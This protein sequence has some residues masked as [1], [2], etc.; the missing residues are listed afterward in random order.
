[1]ISTVQANLDRPVELLIERSGEEVTIIGTPSS[2]RTKQE[3]SLG[4]GL[5]HP[6]RP[7]TLSEIASGG[8]VITA[9]QAAMLVYIP[10][11]LIQGI[12]APE[13]ARVVGF[14]GMFDMFDFAVE[15]DVTSRQEA[16]T[17]PTTT[18]APRPTNWTLNLIGALSVSLGI[19][20]LLPIPALDGGRIL[21]TMPEILFRKRIP[22]EWEN[23]V[24]GIAMLTLI[25]LLLFVNVMDFVNPVTLPVP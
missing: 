6:T 22:M 3:G 9:S 11:A 7:A 16:A 25:A 13:D 19:M 21:F 5:S 2:K 23:M 12:I 4:V 17:A 14:K 24:N 15:E 20:N 18:A 1:M 8:V 10:V